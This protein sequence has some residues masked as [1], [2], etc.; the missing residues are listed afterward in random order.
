MYAE[1]INTNL[2][3][4]YS[5][6]YVSNTCGTDLNNVQV[7]LDLNSTN[8]NFSLVR[9]DLKDIRFSEISN[10]DCAL[11]HWA[12][13][14]F[15]DRSLATV[16]FTVPFIKA[17]ETK[18]I[19][20]FFGY[21]YDN[22]VFNVSSLNFNFVY[23]F[24]STPIDQT[25]WGGH[26]DNIYNS[27][28]G[29]RT[30][31]TYYSNN[32]FY[33][34]SPV[35]EDLNSFEVHIGFYTT[36]DNIS[37][38]LSFAE[39]ENEINFV[40][41]VDKTTVNIETTD[42]V[43]TY[44]QVNQC[45]ESSGYNEFSF[46]YDEGSDLFG[47]SISKRNT[48]E[49]FSIF[50]ERKV[51]GNTTAKFFKL[52]YG[53]ADLYIRWIIIKELTTTKVIVD[54]SELYINSYL[55]NS[56][57]ALDMNSYSPDLTNTY[58]YHYSSCGGSP[59][60][61]S[62][63]TS[64]YPNIWH[65]ALLEAGTKGELIIDFARAGA[66]IVSR[67]Y[68]HYDS[69]HTP[70]Y[71][72]SK[73]SDMDMDSFNRDYWHGLSTTGWACIDF[74]NEYKKVSSVGFMANPDNLTGMMATF[75]FQGG[76]TDPRKSNSSWVTLYEG[77]C[78]KTSGWQQFY[79][80]NNNKYRFY[81]LNV[82][83]TFGTNICIQ[84]W[85]MY[86]GSEETINGIVV[87]QIRLLPVKEDSNDNYFPK[88]IS[89]QGSND[90]VNWDF[91]LKNV[92][93]N[94]PFT[95]SVSCGFWQRYYLS[96]TSK[97]RAYKVILEDNWDDSNNRFAIAEWEMV[98]TMSEYLTLR[99]LPDV[100]RPTM[101]KHH[102]SL[103][104]FWALY[105]NGVSGVATFQHVLTV[106][107][108]PFT[109]EL[110]LY[111]PTSDN[112]SWFT[113]V[114]NVDGTGA[115][116]FLLQYRANGVFSCYTQGTSG[117]Y[118]IY[119]VADSYS[120]NAWHRVSF[121]RSGATGYI[122]VDGI[123]RGQGTIN[124]DDIGK[125][126]KW[127]LGGR[128]VSPNYSTCFIYD[129]RVWNIALT[130][131]QIYNNMYVIPILQTQGL[132]AYYKITEGASTILY[133][134]MDA[135]KNGSLNSG[136]SW[137]SYNYSF[138]NSFTQQIW[139]SSETTFDSGWLY[140]TMENALVKFYNYN[141]PSVHYELYGGYRF[142]KKIIISK[143]YII[144]PLTHFPLL[145][146][147][148]SS[149]GI[150]NQDLTDIFNEIG[151]N[152]KKI[153]VVSNSIDLFVEVEFWSDQNK[154]AILWV[155]HEEWI[156]SNLA[157]TELYLYYDSTAEDNIS[158]V[159]ISSNRPEV[160]DEYTNL[161]Y[162]MRS[163]VDSTNHSYNGVASNS[164]SIGDSIGVVDIATYFDG[165]TLDSI[166][167]NKEAMNGVGDFTI[168]C[169]LKSAKTGA[170]SILSAARAISYNELIFYFANSTTFV[171]SL[172][173]DEVGSLTVPN[174][175]DNEWHFLAWSRDTSNNKYSLFID[176]TL[177]T[178]V[179]GITN[180]LLY[181]DSGG[182]IIGQDQD[183]VGGSF[184]TSQALSGIIDMFKI[185][186]YPRSY[187][188]L[189]LDFLSKKDSLIYFVDGNLFNDLLSEI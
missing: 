104:D 76:Y 94:S 150:N 149:S 77:S 177:Y 9:S 23:V 137:V 39:G 80:V 50:E 57:L 123:L 89:V 106:G 49:D 16:W 58:L 52:I 110:M 17:F 1:K 96:N 15:Y 29:Y 74:G 65:S 98:Q 112:I 186:T 171:P 11:Y 120:F 95:E 168:S 145:I 41:Y 38:T 130:Q 100:C 25:V 56:P 173:N 102:T 146:V 26:T 117:S 154:K 101:N 28:Y 158:F 155:S 151:N 60:N 5:T 91:L 13:E 45:L 36:G 10:G 147:I 32:S 174:I 93:T 114:T 138:T 66:D 3:S 185:D 184:D 47:W 4:F 144:T 34:L 107:I 170:Q 62:D 187:E 14:V 156:L 70:Y 33:T 178:T 99:Y 43:K 73:L 118:T 141:V 53:A 131:S 37:T 81:K 42:V 108:S 182:L 27:T 160:W 85:N 12:A 165:T 143:E 51:E 79:F 119:T 103:G 189:Y 183:L 2:Y 97:Y 148:S 172:K 163:V 113:L 30:Y 109:V 7:K 46:K 83:S 126:T 75:S 48:K 140:L 68:I 63:N 69:G 127:C 136:V 115:N 31:N 153:R 159:G 59:Q 142:V 87:S 139:A 162:S 105:F 88:K 161:Y 82:F 179:S 169:W 135:T 72:A 54:T 116:R 67:S 181:V 134:S 128:S 166:S 121:V 44:N 61:L 157:D 6:I 125:D 180:S 20:V 164:L 84:G 124:S 8:F 19:F 78:A 122:Y 24:N 176:N 167:I 86:E 21:P 111:I 35:I 64:Y 71:N 175:A 92:A 152:Y 55:Y 188:W 18:P 129:L 22:G 133:N 132:S 90:L 40:I